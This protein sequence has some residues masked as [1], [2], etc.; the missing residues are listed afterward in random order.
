MLLNSASSPCSPLRLT[1]TIDADH[2]CATL[3]VDHAEPV[4]AG[5]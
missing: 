4:E 3:T 1:G 5:G 2:G